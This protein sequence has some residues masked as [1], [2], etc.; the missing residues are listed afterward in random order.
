MASSEHHNIESAAFL[1]PWTHRAYL[2]QEFRV[3]RK[4]RFQTNNF[5]IE[6][7]LDAEIRFNGFCELLRP[8]DWV[9]KVGPGGRCAARFRKKRAEVGQYLVR[10]LEIYRTRMRL[11]GR[12]LSNDFLD[13]LNTSAA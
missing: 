7:E 3:V 8:E 1:P 6:A 13:H 11:H 9:N 12:V 10:L 5:L 4:E 2:P